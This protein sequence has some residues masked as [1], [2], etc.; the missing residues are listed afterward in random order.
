MVW[1]QGEPPTPVPENV[2]WYVQPGDYTPTLMSPGLPLLRLGF[3]VPRWT[4][5]PFLVS[6][7]E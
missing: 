1:R 2:R 5:V 6:E 7:Q 3:Y 4:P